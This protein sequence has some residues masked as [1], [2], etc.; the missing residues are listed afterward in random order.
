[1]SQELL[2]LLVLLLNHGGSIFVFG[3]LVTRN[4]RELWVG[5]WIGVCVRAIV[6]S[7]SGSEGGDL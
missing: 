2:L 5:W 4:E 3:W 1:M 7:S 6:W